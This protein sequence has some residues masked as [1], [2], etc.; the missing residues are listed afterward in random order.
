MDHRGGGVKIHRG[1]G[2]GRTGSVEG[3]GTDKKLAE[4][5]PQRRLGHQGG[6][7]GEEGLHMV[8]RIQGSV[9]KNKKTGGVRA[10]GYFTQV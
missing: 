5:N 8:G 6:K 2:G 10:G 9:Q 4:G 7:L 1:R 3:M